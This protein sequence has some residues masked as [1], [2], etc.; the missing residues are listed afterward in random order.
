MSN[1]LMKY[2]DRK[3][4]ETIKIIENFFNKKNLQVQLVRDIENESGTYSCHYVLLFNGKQIL[5]SNGKGTSDLYSK[6]SG[7]AELY[8]RFCYTKYGLTNNPLL[9]SDSIDYLIEKQGY[10]YD[11]KEKNKEEE[12]D[13]FFDILVKKYCPFNTDEEIDNFKTYILSNKIKYIP[14]TT[15]HNDEVIYRSPNLI[16]LVVG[17]TGLSAGNNVQEAFVQGTSELLERIG[18]SR[19]YSIE[20]PKYYYLNENNLNNNIRSIINKIKETNKNVFIYDLSYNFDIPVCMVLIQDINLHDIYV[21]FASNPIIDIAIERCLTEIYQGY[22]KIDSKPKKILSP[23]NKEKIDDIV[24][25]SF[26][27]SD[28]KELMIPENLILNSIQVDHYNYDVFLSGSNIYSNEDLAN[29]II[30]IGNKNKLKF[31]YRDISLDKNMTALQI[32]TDIKVIPQTERNVLITDYIDP[33]LKHKI[34]ELSYA[35]ID[36]VIYLKNNKEY[37]Q[38]QKYLFVIINK[39]K[40]LN[41][42]TEFGLNQI[43]HFLNFDPLDPITGIKFPNPMN[44][45]SAI[46]ILINRSNL[47]SNKSIYWDDIQKFNLYYKY[48]K[49]NETK[50]NIKLYIEFLGY[51]SEDIEDLKLSDIT[52]YYL[53]ENIFIKNFYSLYNSPEY[54]EFIKILSDEI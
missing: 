1:L 39:F 23:F 13:V 34:I 37:K 7:L 47:I 30:E 9:L 46:G 53:F 14:Y 24:I 20:Q 50:E 25:K 41:I 4:E 36:L 19:F 11:I 18:I 45:C 43:F 16:G 40:E 2:K 42:D 52:P 21:N 33:Y 15:Y 3:P 32:I 48:L 28:L 38:A 51:N 26:Q 27:S 29:K 49:N 17:S 44:I 5:S 35:I 12:S 54:K 8:E 6:A 22:E 10:A 31:Y